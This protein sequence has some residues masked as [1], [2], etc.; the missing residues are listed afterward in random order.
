MELA[1]EQKTVE[2]LRI[3]AAKDIGY[4]SSYYKK[5]RVCC[6]DQVSCKFSKSFSQEICWLLEHDS[7]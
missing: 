2:F 7:F 6:K 3:C 4:P 1:L 5:N